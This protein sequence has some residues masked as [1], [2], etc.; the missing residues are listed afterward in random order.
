M[1]ASK[2]LDKARNDTSRND[3]LD[4]GILPPWRAACGTGG[5]IEL[6]VEVVA[7]GVPRSS[8]QLVGQL[9]IDRSRLGVVV[10]RV[11]AIVVIANVE[12]PSLCHRLFTLL[13]TD[14]DLSHL[15]P[16][17]ELILLRRRPSPC[18]LSCRRDMS[19]RPDMVTMFERNGGQDTT[20]ADLGGERVRKRAEKC[21][22][23]AGVRPRAIIE[24]GR[25]NRR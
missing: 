11:S 22:V 7:H 19:R 1:R 14:L 16:S 17:S 10:V 23:W 25:S 4:G 8:W 9:G 24:T 13:T 2:K 20:F 18:S 5:G 3:A 6:S 15:T 21:K 12:I